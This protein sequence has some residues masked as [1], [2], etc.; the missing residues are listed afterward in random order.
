MKF[1]NFGKTL[2][3]VGVFLLVSTMHVEAAQEETIAKGVYLNDVD[4]SGMTKNE[5]KTAIQNY[6]ETLKDKMIT[7]VTDSHKNTEK[8]K[9]LGFSATSSEIL[10]EVMEIGENGNLIARFKELKDVETNKKVY[11]LESSIDKKILESYVNEKLKGYEQDAIEPTITRKDGKFV[12]TEEENGIKIDIDKTIL[13]IS[14]EVNK[15]WKENE[16]TV[17]TVYSVEEP[18]HKAEEL[19]TIKDTLGKCTTKYSRGQVGRTK[20]LELSTSRLDGTIVYP[21]ETISI[22]TLMGPR[23]KAGGY[24]TAKGYYGT[25]VEDTIGA[26]ICQTASTVYNAALEAELDIVERHNHSMIVHY[27]DYAMDST[28][29]AGNDYKNP[30]KDL[31]LKNPY[32]DP[33]YIQSSA[34]GGKCKFTIYGNDTRDKNR[35]VKYVSKTISESWP[36]SITY[37]ND[38]TKKVG[39]TRTIQGS[40]PYVKASLTKQIYVDGKLT[41]S[42]LLHTDV[43]NSANKKVIRG[44]KQP[45]T[46]AAPTTKAPST[47]PSS[48]NQSTKA[49]TKATQAATKAETKAQKETKATKAET[50]KTSKKAE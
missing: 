22:S 45:Q 10:K 36:S 27:V 3:F 30:S 42:K 41:E 21:G 33:I 24:G 23:T 16:L 13:A 29:Y 9:T 4:L 2:A 1:K 32:S 19:R 26:G 8:L 48:K 31:K 15:N 18:K 25:A 20:S 28:I 49:E 39:Y 44:T 47:N 50:T 35:E 12:I 40:F 7:L 14:D 11:E 37:I 6:I 17:N 46:T 43:Y 38:N 34:S 5:A